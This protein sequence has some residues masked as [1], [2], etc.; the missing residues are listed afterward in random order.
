MRIFYNVRLILTPLIPLYLIIYYLKRFVSTPEKCSVPVICVGNIT[1]GGT[2]KTPA[3]IG[4]AKI[5]INMGLK[6]G[7]V[8]RGYRGT[9]SKDGA[10]VTDGKVIHLAPEECGDEPYLMAKALRRVPVAVC[11][12][13]TKAIKYL[14]AGSRIDIVLMDDGFQNNS[15]YKEMNIVI[16]DAT[17][18]FGNGIILPAGDLREPVNSLRRS[19]VIIIN[20]SDLI[21]EHKLSQ[22]TAEINI[23]SKNKEIF[24]SA[25]GGKVLFRMNNLNKKLPVEK[26]K[27]KNILLVSAIGNPD[28]FYRTININEPASIKEITYPDHHYYSLSEIKKIVADSA[29][30]DL[31]ITTEKDF[32]KMREFKLPD[33]IYYLSVSFVLNDS[34]KFR[35]FFRS[36]FKKL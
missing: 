25:Y 22:L 2:G 21:P 16:I 17:N 10:I 36:Y 12:N 29:K 11:A 26:I 27:N 35:K 28:A 15:I 23:K 32:I 31:I 4:L 5:F 33:N 14:L 6:P 8:S 19:D 20:K 9:K 13:R 3:V 7:I 24:Y 34:G 1:T 30:F 18:P